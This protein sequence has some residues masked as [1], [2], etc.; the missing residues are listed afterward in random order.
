MSTI[1]LLLMLFVAFMLAQAGSFFFA[2]LLVVLALILV[3]TSGGE[4][5]GGSGS[6]SGAGGGPIVVQAGGAGYPPEMKFRFQP[7]WKGPKDGHEQIGSNVGNFVDFVGSS[8]VGLG[9]FLFG[10]KKD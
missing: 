3:L 8:F 4:S 2:F 9:R 6:G 10:R 7:D 1:T 5:K